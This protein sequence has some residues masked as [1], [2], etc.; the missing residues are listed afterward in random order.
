M[1]EKMDHQQLSNEEHHILTTEP[2]LS[3]TC[4]SWELGEG[5][6]RHYD[7]KEHEVVLLSVNL[8]GDYKCYELFNQYVAS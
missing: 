7:Q 1:F 5:V 8:K 6:F 3:G 4:L 2:F